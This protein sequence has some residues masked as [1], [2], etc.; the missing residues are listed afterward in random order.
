MKNILTFTLLLTVAMGFV[1]C[2]D[3]GDDPIIDP[4]PSMNEVH[5]GAITSSEIWSAEKIHELAGKVVVESGATLTI[6]EGAIIKGRTGTGSLATALVIAQGG[7][8]MALGTKTK[9]IIFT[10]VLDNIE[11]GQLSGTNLTETDREK[12]GGLIICGKAPVSAEN[13]DILGQIE[14][15]PAD[16]AFGKFGGS[17][18]A[19]NS[20]VLTYISIR[21]GGALIGEGN[22]INGLTL[23][24]VG[25]GTV[26][27]HVEIVGN[28]DDGIECFGGTVN[29]SNALIA[30]HGDDGIDLDMNYSGT[31]D[32]FM[33]IHGGDTDEGLEI[34][35]PE[36]STYTSGLFTLING[37]IVSFDG[38][39][40]AG[41]FKS[42]AQGTVKNCVFSGYTTWIKIRSSYDDG[43]ACALKSDAYK[44][45]TDGFPKLIFE[46]NEILNGP[47]ALAD[48]I[49]AYNN[50]SSCSS[51]LDAAA[52]TALDE[53]FGNSGNVLV[54]SSSKG[55]VKSEFENWTW[56]WSNGKL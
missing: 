16:D 42:K 2:K 49:N 15:I 43:N 6:E 14:G 55:A 35:G 5:S 48:A 8:I 7:K 36:G 56:T 41:D 10:S 27:N 24:G 19:D 47:G 52:Q 34:D 17:D 46:N 32:N 44:Y 3:K 30:F 4:P 51:S 21:H 20:G 29:I 54:T 1:S 33:V 38:A 25:S 28:L 53:V 40:S 39:G 9:P 13:G 23:G 12:W 22:E 37:T 45:M 31:I 26:I 18:P 50:T 11:L